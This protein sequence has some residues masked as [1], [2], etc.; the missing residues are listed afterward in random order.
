MHPFVLLILWFISLCFLWS[1]FLNPLPLFY[2]KPCPFMMHK[3]TWTFYV[4][5]LALPS[6]KSVLPR[7]QE[8]RTVSYFVVQIVFFPEEVVFRLDWI[9]PFVD[10]WQS[11]P[12]C[13]ITQTGLDW[14]R[15][16]VKLRPLPEWTWATLNLS[17]ENSLPS[18]DFF[19]DVMVQYFWP[20]HHVTLR[21][22]YNS[23]QR[24]YSVDTRMHLLLLQSLNWCMFSFEFLIVVDFSHTL[25]SMTL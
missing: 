21:W 13:I 22:H 17:C 9:G 7:D 3:P 23:I 5:V 8:N 4:T 6:A 19:S 2:L 18:K 20:V 16:R 15:L 1:S 24:E 14:C 12:L 11:S 10:T 25:V